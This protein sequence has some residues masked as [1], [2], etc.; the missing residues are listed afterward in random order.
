MWTKFQAQILV[1]YSLI[2]YV[3]DVGIK[4]VNH[5][6]KTITKPCFS[7]T[8]HFLINPRTVSRFECLFMLIQN[9]PLQQL[10]KDW[11]CHP[12]SPTR[13]WQSII[14]NLL[15]KKLLCSIHV[16]FSHPSVCLSEG[17]WSRGGEGALC[18]P[19]QY[20]VTNVP[21]PNLKV[22]PRSLCLSVCLSIY[23]SI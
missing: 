18:P 21:P 5:L 15:N 22:A 12:N 6:G 19:L 8:R 4:N 23:L 14:N 13:Q 20:W 3:L 17:Q 1:P 2:L 11:A 9:S 10:Q 16:T 7:W